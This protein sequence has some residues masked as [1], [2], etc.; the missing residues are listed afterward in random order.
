MSSEHAAR[1]YRRPES[2]G[3]LYDVLER[4]F[5][6]YRTGSGG[7]NISRLAKDMGRSHETLYRALRRKPEAG[8]PEGLLKVAIAL[9]LLEFSSEC[10][11]ENPL[12]WHDLLEYVLPHYGRFNSRGEPGFDDFE[13]LLS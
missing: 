1:P 7:M 2:F 8:F 13:D 4:H 12:T 9:D 6:G 11:P 3:S 5:R 10:H